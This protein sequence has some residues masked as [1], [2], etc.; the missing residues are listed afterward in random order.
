MIR[1]TGAAGDS[2]LGTPPGDEKPMAVWAV[3]GADSDAPL[4]GVP[5]AKPVERLGPQVL[6]PSVIT[7]TSLVPYGAAL[8]IVALR[9]AERGGQPAPPSLVPLESR[10]YA[11][12]KVA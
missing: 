10:S 5:K 8:R 7:W 6:L 2:S 3:F 4:L 9:E 11:T 1:R 12:L